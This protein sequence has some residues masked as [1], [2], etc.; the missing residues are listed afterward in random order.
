MS[1]LKVRTEPL[2]GLLVIDIKR[3]GDERGF[4]EESFKNEALRALGIQEN[5]IQDNM[6]LSAPGV[7]RGMHS[8]RRFTQGKWVRC[9]RGRIYDVAIDLRKGSETY[10]QHYGLELSESESV[11]FYI[12]PGFGHGFS[13]FSNEPALVLYK[14][15]DKYDPES[16][17]GVHPLDPGLAIDWQ[18]QPGVAAWSLSEKDQRLPLFSEYVP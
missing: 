15:T 7:L 10:G 18:K 16:E 11:A 13:V 2:R 17:C 5:F 8:Q 3:F 12:P 9:L 14:V 4:F 1:H 6:S